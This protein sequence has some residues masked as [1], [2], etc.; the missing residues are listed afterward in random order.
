LSI[1]RYDFFGHFYKRFTLEVEEKKTNLFVLPGDYVGRGFSIME[2]DFEGGFGFKRFSLV[3]F[4]V[5]PF[6]SSCVY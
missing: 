3:S 2:L 6:I 1:T 5:Y 4:W